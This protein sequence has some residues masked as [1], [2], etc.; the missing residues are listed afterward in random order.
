MGVSK[1]FKV[2]FIYY[3][4]IK[5]KII[6]KFSLSLEYKPLKFDQLKYIRSSN[7]NFSNSK[8]KECLWP[9]ITIHSTIFNDL[10]NENN[11]NNNITFNEKEFII[12]KAIVFT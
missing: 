4:I 6:K 7:S 5:L 8:I 2:S 12:V 10:N 3:K 1:I 11:N 9:G